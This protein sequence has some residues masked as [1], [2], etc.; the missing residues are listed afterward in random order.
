MILIADSG[1]TKCDWIAVDKTGVLPVQKIRTKGLNPAILNA[2]NLQGILNNSEALKALQ[3]TVT[4]IYFYG[5]GCGTAIPKALLKAVLE[6][7]Y[8]KATVSVNEDTMAAVYATIT[9]KNE[10]GIVCILGTGSNCS[11]FDGNSVHQKI[12]SLGY[13]L[14]DDASGNY[15]GKQLL[16][17]YYF[18]SMP[19]ELKEV[20]KNTYD[21][22]PDTIKFNLYKQPNPN[23]YL[24]DFAEFMVNNKSTDYC[25][26][27]IIKGMRLF[28]ETMILQYKEELKIYPVHFA[29]SL[30]YYCQDEIQIVAK[31]FGFKTGR[32]VKRPIEGLVAY[33]TKK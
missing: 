33:H 27:L 5:A 26:N 12:A 6:A 9:T 32:F 8:I 10:A 25:N 18:N 21:I 22:T 17:D 11:F 31:E 13:T 24:A 2:E 4:E 28:A 30:A 19:E 16:R 23:A 15:Y 7:V 29:G 3:R 1:S 14:M 20:F